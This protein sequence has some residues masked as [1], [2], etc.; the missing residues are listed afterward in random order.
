MTRVLLNESFTW[1]ERNQIS[2]SSRLRKE[3]IPCRISLPLHEDKSLREH[4][5]GARASGASA[6]IMGQCATRSAAV[7][8][9]DEV[10]IVQQS[11]TR[12]RKKPLSESF[13][14]VST[15]TS[16]DAFDPVNE[17]ILRRLKNDDPSFTLLTVSS[18][19]T[20]HLFLNSFCARCSRDL[21]LVG[22]VVSS[23]TYLTE[24]HVIMLDNIQFETDRFYKGLSKNKTLKSI[25]LSCT[26]VL[27]G[28]VFGMLA[29]F[30]KG[31]QALELVVVDGCNI[32]PIGKRMLSLALEGN[33]N[34]R[35][36]VLVENGLNQNASVSKE[37]QREDL[38]VKKET[39][40]NR[41]S[42]SRRASDS[43]SKSQRMKLSKSNSTPVH[44]DMKTTEKALP[45][46][47]LV[48][49]C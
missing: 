40:K 14:T 41:R 23:N 31:N 20:D 17:S 15:E 49:C 5:I 3:A 33:T 8:P 34:P 39:Q 12:R 2:L 37:T 16:A 22:D 11:I 44:S 28:A 45:R 30:F 29:P 46:S 9:I 38:P 27:G 42:K 4:R 13:T 7:A 6:T 47:N 25:R 21:Q 48:H 35:L 1:W 10:E 24:L 18:E 43:N 19:D 36:K 32:P 26:D